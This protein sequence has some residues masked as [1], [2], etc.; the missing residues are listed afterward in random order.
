MN[1]KCINTLSSVLCENIRTF[2]SGDLFSEFVEQD[3]IKDVLR[4][5]SGNVDTNPK[6][7][8]FENDTIKLIERWQ[9][10]IVEFTKN[11]LKRWSLK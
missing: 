1:D 11:N 4:K 2:D 7:S 8:N 6:I 5:Y 10:S 9:E 3:E